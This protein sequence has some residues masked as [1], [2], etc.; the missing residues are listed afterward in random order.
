MSTMIK[1]K[2]QQKVKPKKKYT[3]KDKRFR[4][5]TKKHKTNFWELQN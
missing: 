5:P 1:S 3:E 2:K 4:K